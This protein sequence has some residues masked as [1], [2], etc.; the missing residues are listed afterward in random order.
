MRASHIEP[1]YVIGVTDSA[2]SMIFLNIGD[3]DF[4]APPQAQV[5]AM[6]RAHVVITPGRDFGSADTG[7]FVHF[8]SALGYLPETADRLR[9]LLR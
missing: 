1:F 6:R 4:T 5:A 8:P 7:C 2:R 9:E 3:P